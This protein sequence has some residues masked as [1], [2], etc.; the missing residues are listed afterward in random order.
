[1]EPDFLW[2]RIG[3]EI[4]LPLDP[5]YIRLFHFFENRKFKNSYICELLIHIYVYGSM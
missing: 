1:M 2:S 4:S 3:I 5:Y